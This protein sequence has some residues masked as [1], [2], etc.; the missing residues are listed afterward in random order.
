MNAKNFEELLMAVKGTDPAEIRGEEIK[1]VLRE[2]LSGEF[3][4]VKERKFKFML[5]KPKGRALA[6]INKVDDTVYLWLDP[7]VHPDS[8]F[9]L[10]RHELLHLELGLLDDSD[11]RF[12]QA[13]RERGIDIWSV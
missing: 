11:P 6:V 9:A 4:K 8:I 13:A 1:R 12:Q 5:E 7:D 10:L 3:S 2:L